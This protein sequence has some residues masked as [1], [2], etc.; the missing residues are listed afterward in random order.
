MGLAGRFDG[1]RQLL[2]RHIAGR[3][4]KPHGE[5]RFGKSV[6]SFVRRTASEPI[7][8]S[9][10]RLMK[11]TAAAVAQYEPQPFAGRA[12][13]VFPSR[14]CVPRRS[15]LKWRAINPQ[16]EQLY[17]PDGCEGDVMLLEPYAAA[18]ADLFRKI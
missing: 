10:A 1:A 15:M 7:L 6:E 12:V 13:L 5:D 18:A 16:I 11:I 17:G 14:G 2:R 9:R 4:I 3:Q 8:I